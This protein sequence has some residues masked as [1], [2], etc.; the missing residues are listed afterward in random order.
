M[1]YRIVHN[2]QTGHTAWKTWTLSVGRSSAISEPVTTLASEDIERAA[3]DQIRHQTQRRRLHAAGKSFL[4]A[5]ADWIDCPLVQFKS[6]C[7][8]AAFPAHG[9]PL[10]M[11]AADHRHSFFRS[12]TPKTNR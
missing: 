3:L 11:V 12:P 8:Q 7:R 4:T 2:E 9:T 6:A 1:T 10:P 5:T